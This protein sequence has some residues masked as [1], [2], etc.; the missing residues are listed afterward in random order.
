[1]PCYGPCVYAGCS[2]MDLGTDRPNGSPVSALSSSVRSD[3]IWG[4]A[5]A[6]GAVFKTHVDGERT[7]DGE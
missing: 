6:Q 1:M 7:E 5:Y 3:H 4:T 2:E